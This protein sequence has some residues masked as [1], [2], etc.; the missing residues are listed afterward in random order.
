MLHH[1]LLLLIPLTARNN[2]QRVIA[3]IMA[4]INYTY[5]RDVSVSNPQIIL[6]PAVTNR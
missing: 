2:G 6:L 3:L 1:Q 5:L 4:G